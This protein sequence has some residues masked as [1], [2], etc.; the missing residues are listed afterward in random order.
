[1]L[2]NLRTYNLAVQFHRTG[3]NMRLPSYLRDQWLRAS[4]S[5]VLN[6]AEGYG[7]STSKDR[8]RFY[9]IAMGSLRECQAVLDLC[10]QP[11]PSLSGLADHLGGSLYKLIRLT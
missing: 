4:S 3:K 9:S 2:K 1:M 6:I 8:A 10:D 5:I 11:A 7:K